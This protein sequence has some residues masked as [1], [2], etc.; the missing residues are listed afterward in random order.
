VAAPI[1]K[2]GKVVLALIGNSTSAIALQDQ[3]NKNRLRLGLEAKPCN[4]LPDADLDLYSECIAE[5]YPNGQ[6][7]FLFICE[8]IA[9]FK[10]DFA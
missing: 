7:F 1:M 8:S 2:S 9:E 10:N 6:H 5:V 3:H 4:N